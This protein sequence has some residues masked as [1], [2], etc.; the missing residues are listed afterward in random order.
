[1][2]KVTSWK[3]ALRG[4][5]KK[6]K[7]V[8]CGKLLLGIPPK[9]VARQMALDVDDK[10][11]RDVLLEDVRRLAKQVIPKTATMHLKEPDAMLAILKKPAIRIFNFNEFIENLPDQL[12]D[13]E[14]E[15]YIQTPDGRFLLMYMS[16]SSFYCSFEFTHCFKTLPFSI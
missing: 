1:M 8:I 11:D 15:K 2:K 5:V 12:S 10:V 6:T 7:E 9:E 4:S 13:A 3:T 16:D 14:R